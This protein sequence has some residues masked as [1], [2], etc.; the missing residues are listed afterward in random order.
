MTITRTDAEALLIDRA[1]AFMALVEMDS[2][3]TDGTNEDL[4][5]PI[6]FALLALGHTAV[7]NLQNVSDTDLEAVA[8]DEVVAFLDLAEYR[9]LDTILNKYDDVDIQ[10]GTRTQKY[11]QLADRMEE[12]LRR[13][14]DTIENV[15]GIGLGSLEFGVINLSFATHG[16]DTVV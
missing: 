5:G 2:T 9:L 12:K 14:G 11:H 4:N 13:I 3:T 1:D 15:H 6:L 8:E 16:D 7:E 10:V